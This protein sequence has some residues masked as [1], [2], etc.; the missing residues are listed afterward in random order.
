MRAVGVLGGSFNP[1]HEGH[2]YISL[3]ALK[4]LGLDE[5]WWMVSPQNPLKPSRGMAPY[6]ARIESAR[7]RA[8]HPRIKVTDIERRLG[9]RYTAH[10]LQA[11]KRRFPR[12]QFVW[13]M[14]ADNLI[15][16]PHWEEWPAIFEAVP[17]AVF[18]RP[19]YSLR[20]RCS[21]AAH[22]FRRSR[23]PA[24]RAKGLVRRRPP[25]WVF[26]DGRTHPASA[27]SI[28][29]QQDRRAAKRPEDKERRTK[30]NRNRGN[31][32]KRATP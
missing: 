26:L 8:S 18:S 1:A 11:L 25:A 2:R 21:K 31:M 10:S 30:G 4:R 12:V 9:T 24:W 14:G 16:I 3:Q 6:S 15:E 5:I 27:T 29:A 13:L 32:N 28:R 20:A 19:T 22:R 7:E 23:L 17:I